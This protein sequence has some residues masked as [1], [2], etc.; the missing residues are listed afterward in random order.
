MVLLAIKLA[1]LALLWVLFFSPA[2][3]IAV[4]GQAAGRQLA[5]APSQGTHD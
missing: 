3:R 1:A 2:H 5:V 4:D